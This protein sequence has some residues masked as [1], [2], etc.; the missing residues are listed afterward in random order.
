ML[1]NFLIIVSYIVGWSSVG[2]Y[3]VPAVD[4]PSWCSFD[5]ITCDIIPTSATYRSVKAIR[6]NFLSG[7]RL[8]PASF[9]SIRATAVSA[10]LPSIITNFINLEELTLTGFYF[11]GTIPASIYGMSALTIIDLSYNRLTGTIDSAIGTATRL[12][13][14]FL[15]GNLLGG[16]IPS[17]IGSMGSLTAL[18]LNSNSLSGTIPSTIV[19]LTNLRELD[20]TTNVLTGTIPDNIGNIGTQ[21]GYLSLEYNLL[22]GTIPSTFDQLALGSFSLDTNYL[23]M[24][25]LSTVPVSTFSLYT[26]DH[27]NG[28]ELVDNCLAFRYGDIEVFATHCKPTA[29]KLII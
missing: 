26:I 15:S 23:T 25:S 10:T 17:T 4:I 27:M 20:L 2:P 8:L 21:L 19:S 9:S 11:T 29:G 16:T 18:Y 3:D 13:G 1:L 28:Y 12:V 14:L 7:R 24:G 22:T 5:G 6:Y